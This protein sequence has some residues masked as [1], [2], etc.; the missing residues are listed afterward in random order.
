MVRIVKHKSEDPMWGDTPLLLYAQASTFTEMVF[1]MFSEKIPTKNECVLFDLLL[2]L[3][4]DHGAGA[5]SAKATI[6]AAMRGDTMGSAVGDGIREINAV[7]GGATEGAMRL[8]EEI[9]EGKTNAGD[10]V[11]NLIKER[12]RVPGFGHRLYKKDPRAELIMETII[13]LGF[14]RKYPVIAREVE[15]ALTAHVPGKILPLNIDGA[16]GAAL[17]TLGWK[18]E[19][20]TAVFIAARSAGLAAHYLHNK[21]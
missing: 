10:A 13:R 1:E 7:H 8:F 19:V 6:A 16:I 5:P 3:S 12:R 11:A 9:A 4:L 21:A 17:S 15:T 18:P 2:K 20:S 14:P